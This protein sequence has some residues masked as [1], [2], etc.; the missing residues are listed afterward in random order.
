MECLLEDEQYQMH[1]HKQ[2]YTQSDMEECVRIANESRMY[3]ASCTEQRAHCRDQH[4]VAQ[5][6][7]GGGSDTAKTEEHPEYK[8]IVQWSVQ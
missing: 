8:H 7:Q 4:K 1:M 2:G 6:Y 3:V 5:P